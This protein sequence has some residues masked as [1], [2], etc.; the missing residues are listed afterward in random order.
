MRVSVCCRWRVASLRIFIHKSAPCRGM[1]ILVRNSESIR[2]DGCCFQDDPGQETKETKETK[3]TRIHRS[4]VPHPWWPAFVAACR[5]TNSRAPEGS[6][7]TVLWKNNA[8]TGKKDLNEIEDTGLFKTKDRATLRNLFLHVKST[9]NYQTCSKKWSGSE[10]KF[11][12]FGDFTI[13]QL[14]DR[15]TWELDSQEE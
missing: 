4:P 2:R 6:A 11:M 13:L 3:E 9:K 7:R 8:S 5:A 12:S 14:R 1:A 15:P 10:G